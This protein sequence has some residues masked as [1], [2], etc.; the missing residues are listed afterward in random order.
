MELSEVDNINKLVETFTQ[1]YKS[2]LDP[3]FKK[4]STEQ[5]TSYLFKQFSE[6]GQSFPIVLKLIGERNLYY[7][8]AFKK[9]LKYLQRLRGNDITSEAQEQPRG[10]DAMLAMV[11]RQCLYIKFLYEADCKQHGRHINRSEQQRWYD[12][13]YDSLSRM[14]KRVKD[15]EEKVGREFDKKEAEL[16]QAKR[17]ELL[18][19]IAMNTPRGHN[20]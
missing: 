11:E 1:I 12:A 6:L 10:S 2:S 5:R 13:E 7:P 20:D 14:V 19:F 15:T 9:Y 18:A 4:I 8:G 16:L 3:E 17:D